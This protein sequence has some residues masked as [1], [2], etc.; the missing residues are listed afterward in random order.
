MSKRYLAYVED[1]IND[2]YFDK[3][4]GFRDHEYR[5]VEEYSLEFRSVSYSFRALFPSNKRIRS[6]QFYVY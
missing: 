5:I 6:I 4:S 3:L 2:L 1:F